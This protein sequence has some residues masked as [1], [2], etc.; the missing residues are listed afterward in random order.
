MAKV[1]RFRSPFSSCTTRKRV[2][3]VE[4]G[5]PPLPVWLWNSGDIKGVRGIFILSLTSSILRASRGRM[6]GSCAYSGP[7]LWYS[8]PL[9]GLLT[10]RVVF[11]CDQWGLNSETQLWYQV[12]GHL[13]VSTTI[14]LRWYRRDGWPFSS[15][16]TAKMDR[17]RVNFPAQNEDV[18][19]SFWRSD[20]SQE[21]FPLIKSANGHQLHWWPNNAHYSIDLCNNPLLINTQWF[22]NWRNLNGKS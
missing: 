21:L 14:K 15:H 2:S 22:Q 19:R 3:K 5:G 6:F 10:V 18:F 4:V 17:K 16:K 7:R 1:W 9:Y 20:P 13:S 12:R 8:T 11:H